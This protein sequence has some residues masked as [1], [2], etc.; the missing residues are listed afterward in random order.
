MIMNE[1]WRFPASLRGARGDARSSSDAA[2][3]APRARAP[4]NNN[5]NNDVLMSQDA[6]E[7]KN[8]HN[9]LAIK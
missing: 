7:M 8:I 1:R 6:N 4:N 9:K 2:K 3:T 5:N